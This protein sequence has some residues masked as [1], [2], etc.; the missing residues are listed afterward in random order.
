MSATDAT[1]SAVP[2]DWSYGALKYRVSGGEIY[3]I[4]DMGGTTRVVGSLL[5]YV[6]GQDEQK[7]LVKII[8]LIKINGISDEYIDMA[9][10]A[11]SSMSRFILNEVVLFNAVSIPHEATEKYELLIR[12]MLE[13]NEQSYETL[14][15]MCGCII[16]RGTC[17]LLNVFKMIY[18]VAYN[19]TA[20]TLD[21]ILYTTT[22]VGCS[23]EP[24]KEI[25]RIQMA[26]LKVI[27]DTA[28]HDVGMDS[29]NTQR[30]I[31]AYMNALMKY[32]DGT[33][34]YQTA[35]LKVMETH[36]N[37]LCYNSGPIWFMYEAIKRDQE[38]AYLMWSKL[39]SRQQNMLH[40]QIVE[41]IKAVGLLAP[42][43]QL[44]TLENADKPIEFIEYIVRFGNYDWTKWL[45]AEHSI[46]YRDHRMPL[47]LWM[48]L[49]KRNDVLLDIIRTSVMM[50]TLPKPSPEMGFGIYALRNKLCM[51]IDQ[52]SH[53]LIDV[54]QYPSK[55]Q[56]AIVSRVRMPYNVLPREE[57]MT[58]D[59]MN[60]INIY[61]VGY[62]VRTGSDHIITRTYGD[63]VEV[64]VV[65]NAFKRGDMDVIASFRPYTNVSPMLPVDFQY[66]VF[67]NNKAL[68]TDEALMDRYVALGESSMYA[69]ISVTD[70]IVLCYSHDVIV[71][72]KLMMKFALHGSKRY[73]LEG[74]RFEDH[75]LRVYVAV[76]TDV[77][78]PKFCVLNHHKPVHI[79][80]CNELMRCITG[81][82]YEFVAI[83]NDHVRYLYNRHDIHMKLLGM[84]EFVLHMLESIQRRMCKGL[85]ETSMGK[86][87]R[88]VAV[89]ST[90]D[91]TF[92][93]GWYMAEF[94]ESPEELKELK[95]YMPETLTMKQMEDLYNMFKPYIDCYIGN[96]KRQ[97]DLEC[98]EMLDY[99]CHHWICGEDLGK[100]SGMIAHVVS[101]ADKEKHL[102]LI[103]QFL[104]SPVRTEGVYELLLRK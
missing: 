43:R 54:I 28:N 69:M 58:Y 4:D 13:H 10:E 91:I 97:L 8:S 103:K 71:N 50:P 51:M 99:V 79:D 76:I 39:G 11:L 80:S 20:S 102:E 67:K 96:V 44:E 18:P 100:I 89:S 5:D 25:N 83:E 52:M 73:V 65:H 1:T 87:M 84:Y 24:T 49:F 62:V 33:S 42:H 45:K 47:L 77:C 29:K 41:S 40:G 68:F 92:S 101:N 38:F 35:V 6:W 9:Y 34:W 53:F 75:L 48:K 104:A 95:Q 74:L 61:S 64:F 85:M 70:Y 86:R 59:V 14:W 3:K 23:R 90:G 78:V 7:A 60:R 15:K 30:N 88:G 2:V 26:M 27:L 31:M 46:M 98:I 56:Y 55:Y 82:R 19:K 93:K 32:D 22:L 63:P 94:A 57:L 12:H 21:E 36:M 17:D 37:V 16:K 72:R 81:K 66:S